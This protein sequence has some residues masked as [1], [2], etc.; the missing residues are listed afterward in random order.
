MC[1]SLCDSVE[2]SLV[3][4]TDMVSAFKELPAGPQFPYLY[5]RDEDNPCLPG[6]LWGIRSDGGCDGCERSL[7]VCIGAGHLNLR[8]LML[9]LLQ[10]S[11]QHISSSSLLLVLFLASSTLNILRGLDDS[12]EKLSYPEPPCLL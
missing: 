2:Y 9:L 1:W 3:K 12:T 10:E 4:K 5:K 8:F 6:L 11:S 7:L